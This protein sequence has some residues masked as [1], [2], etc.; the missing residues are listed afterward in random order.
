MNPDEPENLA[1]RMYLDPHEKPPEA[2]K[3]IFKLWKNSQNGIPVKDE[4]QLSSQP[5]ELSS[6]TNSLLSPQNLE[7]VFSRFLEFERQTGDNS[8]RLQDSH[9]AF[10]GV[11]AE[12]E[13][14]KAGF[15]Y[16]SVKIQGRL[17]ILCGG[18]SLSVDGL[19]LL[20]NWLRLRSII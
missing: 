19:G 5:A 14:C 8:D 20:R 6:P 7:R 2:L 17:L 16:D 18:Y 11:A 4:S 12:I 10:D 9:R 13:Q 3:A 15:F 1:P